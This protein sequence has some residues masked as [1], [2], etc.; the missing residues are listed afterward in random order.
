MKYKLEKTEN[1]QSPVSMQIHIGKL[2]RVD[3]SRN[4]TSQLRCKHTEP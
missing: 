3:T 2:P 1:E 4:F